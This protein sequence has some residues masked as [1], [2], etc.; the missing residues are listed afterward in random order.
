MVR[1]K[2]GFLQKNPFVNGK[3]MQAHY[4]KLPGRPSR[5]A[6]D[7]AA[8]VS[9]GS[10]RVPFVFLKRGFLKFLLFFFGQRFGQLSINIPLIRSIFRLRRSVFLKLRNL[11]FKKKRGF[12]F[13]FRR[14]LGKGTFV[15]PLGSLAKRNS[16]L[17]VKGK[18]KRKRFFLRKPLLI[19][20]H[21]FPFKGYYGFPFFMNVC[22]DPFIFYKEN[23][24]KT[25]AFFF[26]TYARAVEWVF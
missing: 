26:F 20:R 4:K 7:A 16:S 25:L 12:F 9:R 3:A 24:S 22:L 13:G 2:V 5:L 14:T 18:G 23:F 1:S 8:L 11:L 21:T 17:L 10:T 15:F 19:K 6:L